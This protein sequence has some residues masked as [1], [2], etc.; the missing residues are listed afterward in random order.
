MMKDKY[1]YIEPIREVDVKNTTKKES[2]PRCRVI[3][4]IYILNIEYGIYS[5]CS[6]TRVVNI[7][8]ASQVSGK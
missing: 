1:T 2:R 7:R 5:H 6:K 8:V 3:R 4:L